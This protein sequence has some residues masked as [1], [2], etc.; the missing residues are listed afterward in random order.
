[1]AG[2]DLAERHVLHRRRSEGDHDAVLALVERPYSGRTETQPEQ[3]VERGRC[4][5]AKQVTQ[6]HR[7]GLLAGQH[8]QLCGDFLADATESLSLTNGLAQHRHAAANPAGSLG[9]HDDGE[10]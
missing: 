3:P 4:A 1:M 7:A 8:L 10:L 9:D 5:A 2:T 6:H